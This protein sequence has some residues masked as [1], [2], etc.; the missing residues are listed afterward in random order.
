MRVNQCCGYGEVPV[1]IGRTKSDPQLET[2]NQQATLDLAA[3]SHR[4]CLGGTERIANSTRRVPLLIPF[5]RIDTA[6]NFNNE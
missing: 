2:I 4:D 1:L 3:V 6:L 5:E